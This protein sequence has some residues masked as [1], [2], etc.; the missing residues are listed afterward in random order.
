[1]T[2]KKR[3]VKVGMEDSY[4]VQTIRNEPA[5]QEWPK[6]ALPFS[7]NG[8]L[9]GTRHFGPRFFARSLCLCLCLCLSRSVSLA[10][11]LSL[12]LYLSP[13]SSH[14]QQTPINSSFPSPPGR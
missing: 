7:E 5:V 10:L 3:Q 2:K 8:L 13:T 6:P 11:S 14:T 9:I 12:Y 1:M 4:V